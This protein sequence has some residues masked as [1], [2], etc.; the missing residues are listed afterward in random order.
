MP[1]LEQWNEIWDWLEPWLRT[2]WSVPVFELVVR[3]E[4]CGRARGESWAYIVLGRATT[5]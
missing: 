3:E 4:R 2:R 1:L 5:L